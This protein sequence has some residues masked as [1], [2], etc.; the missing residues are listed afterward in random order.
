MKYPADYPKCKVDEAWPMCLRLLDQDSPLPGIEQALAPY[1]AVFDD[2]FA[3]EQAEHDNV[4]YK[5]FTG[6]VNPLYLDHYAKLI[7]RFSRALFLQKVDTTLLDA[8]FFSIKSRTGMD[9]FYGLQLPEYFLP[10]HAFGS[11]LGR[12]TY[13]K[14]LVVLQ[15][16]T[17]GHNK[18]I[19]PTF[20][21]GVILRP[22]AMVL[23]NSH[24][25]RNVQIAAGA[26]LIDKDIPDN[27]IVM[28]RVPDLIIKPN[29]QDNIAQY[30]EV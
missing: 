8:M 9:L 29:P 28:G 16:C 6:V 4:K 23:G 3:H 30:F 27:S 18:E 13:S 1:R 5:Y 19:Y 15:H 21:E 25:G 11:I 14:Y 7:Y 12:A 22:G 20:G 24:I 10:L 2:V 26:F 17:I